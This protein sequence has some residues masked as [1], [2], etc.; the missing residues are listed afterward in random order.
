M[1]T[2]EQVRARLNEDL[3]NGKTIVLSTKELDSPSIR[4]QLPQLLEELSR[5]HATEHQSGPRIP[6]YTMLGEIGQGGMSTV[7]LARQDNLRRHVAIKIAPK[8]LGCGDRARRM[9]VQEA[10][11]MARL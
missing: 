7:Y 8:W 3:A 5:T 10:N 2:P 6:G 11:A 9:L 1:Q 4:E